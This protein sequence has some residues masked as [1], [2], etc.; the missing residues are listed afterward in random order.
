MITVGIDYDTHGVHLVRLEDDGTPAYTHLTTPG[1]DSFARLR[2]VPLEM[3][4]TGWWDDVTA[5]AIEEPA[6]KYA[7]A[8]L[9][10]VQGAIVACLPDDLLVAPYL[11]VLW[12]KLIGLGGNAAKPAVMDWVYDQLGENPQWPQDACDAYCLARV[13]RDQV[14]RDKEV[15]T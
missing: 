12:K 10:A 5:C 11:A 9:K 3:P 14:V 6:G 13:I 8:K 2:Q 15:P 4:G 1:Q 7:V